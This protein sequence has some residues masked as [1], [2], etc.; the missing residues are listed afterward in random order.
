MR[1]VFVTGT[2]TGVGKTITSAL[3]ISALKK[4]GLPAKY[5][6]PIQTGLDD[7]T[8]TLK[9]LT[10]SQCLETVYK[11]R[12]PISPNRAAALANVVI[13]LQK[14]KSAIPSGGKDFFVVEGAGG[15]MVPLNKHENIRDLIKLLDLPLVIVASTRLGTINHT[16]LTLECAR[17]KNIS[18]KG[19]ILVGPEDPGL[20]ETIEGLGD[21]P[22][23]TEI[24]TL[25]ISPK[26][27]Q[28]QGA[29]LFSERNLFQIF[30]AW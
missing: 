16:L 22:I 29:K 5:F 3:L 21:I 27:I 25:N 18:I 19:V 8:E 24:P 14:I 15:L 13:E 12:D 23:L 6:K 11:F 28:S 17:I 10:E 9:S 4:S 20:K 7:D 26:E 30:G 2:D 1:G